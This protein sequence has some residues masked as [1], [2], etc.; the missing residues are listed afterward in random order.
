LKNH[1]SYE[2]LRVWARVVL[3]S[4]TSPAHVDLTQLGR[5]TH[6][7]YPNFHLAHGLRVANNATK[8]QR[9]S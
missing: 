6:N 2:Y 3:A 4:S 5:K 1:A 7:A 8:I 9:K